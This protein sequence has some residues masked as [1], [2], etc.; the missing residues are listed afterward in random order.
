MLHR[1]QLLQG[2]QK[3]AWICPLRPV[4]LSKELEGGLQQ[5]TTTRQVDELD[6][7]SYR[8]THVYHVLQIHDLMWNCHGRRES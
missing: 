3:S 1:N 6:D 4:P 7:L 8:S 2:S 5:V